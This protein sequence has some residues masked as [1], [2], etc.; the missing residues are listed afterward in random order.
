MKQHQHKKSLL[1]QEE[2]STH[3]LEILVDGVFAIAMT[4]LVLDIRLPDTALINNPHDLWMQLLVLAPKFFS[5]LISFMILATFWAGHHTEFHYIKKLDHTL[6]W[7]NIFYLLFVCF[8]PFTASLLGSYL[9]NQTAVIIYGANLIIMVAIH[10]CMW[11]HASHHE[12]L[13]KEN[14][15]PDVDKLVDRLAIFAIVGYSLAI[16]LSFLST[17]ASLIIYIITPL[18]YISGWIYTMV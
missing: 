6:I 11:Q 3:R 2:I 9:Y 15:H 8:T 14:V 17:A 18:P 5:F 1:S 4:L 7:F 10:Y 13:L 12:N 16:A